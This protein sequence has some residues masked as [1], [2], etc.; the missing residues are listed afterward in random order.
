MGIPPQQL[1]RHPA[2]HRLEGALRWTSRPHLCH[3]SFA[4]TKPGGWRYTPG[5]RPGTS[6]AAECSSISAVSAVSAAGSPGAPAAVCGLHTA[7]AT[8]AGSLYAALCTAP[9]WQKEYAVCFCFWCSEF[10]V[11]KHAELRAEASR[12]AEGAAG[13]DAAADARCTAEGDG[14]GSHEKCL[15]LKPPFPILGLYLENPVPLVREIQDV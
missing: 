4:A 1:G 12:A 5:T 8:A 13:A 9:R 10:L 7:A 6:P 2:S 3:H 15:R 14:H 11:A